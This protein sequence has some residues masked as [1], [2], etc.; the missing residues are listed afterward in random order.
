M[1]GGD[2]VVRAA[3]DAGRG[4]E[5]GATVEFGKRVLIVDDDASLTELVGEQF[6]RAGG[7]V[8][9]I[10]A[11]GAAALAL[12]PAET[13]DAI[14]LDAGL[15]DIDGC[16]VLRQLRQAGVRCPIVL[17]IEE[18]KDSEAHAAAGL[19]AG[20]SACVAKPFRLGALLTR[21]QAELRQHERSDD[22]AVAVGPYSFHA[23]LKTLIH[24]ATGARI[25]LTDKEAAIVSYLQRAGDRV[26]SRSLLLE[27]VWG[28]NAH[29]TTHTLE[30]HIYRLRR[31]IEPIPGEANLLITEAGGYRLVP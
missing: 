26:V 12:V 24:E 6:V 7:F 10:A 23:E 15:P 18:G 21:V 20:A 30:T 3:A 28:Y 29:V 8:V 5:Q 13:F 27:Q 11:T 2:E 16:Q 14:I 19:A 25:R 31:K 9:E 4:R 17:L 22:A 1:A